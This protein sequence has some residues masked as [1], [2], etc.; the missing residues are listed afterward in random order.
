LNQL[1]ARQS[2]SIEAGNEI[3]DD[4]IHAALPERL[5]RRQSTLG[6]QSTPGDRSVDLSPP[7]DKI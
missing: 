1:P 6:G 4:G 3:F 7:S 5:A 2:A